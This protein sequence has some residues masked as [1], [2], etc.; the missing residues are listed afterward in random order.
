MNQTAT[1]RTSTSMKISAETIVILKNFATINQGILISAGNVLQT[2]TN[3]VFAEA[4]IAETFPVEFGIFNLNN[5][6]NVVSLFKDPEFEFGDTFLRISE[7]NGMAETK[8]AYAG[9]GMVSLP[10]KGKKRPVP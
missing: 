9:A 2:R 6:L 4:K 8:Y 7:A 10:T 3:S 1:K 5:F